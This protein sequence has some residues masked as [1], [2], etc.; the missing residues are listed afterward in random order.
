MHDC[1]R[2]APR[3]QRLAALPS[4]Q[5][6][7]GRGACPWERQGWV[8]HAKTQLDARLPWTTAHATSFGWLGTRVGSAYASPHTNPRPHR[9]RRRGRP[10]TPTA[11]SLMTTSCPSWSWSACAPGSPPA[12]IVSA[13]TR[14][15][16]A[17]LIANPLAG[18]AEDLGQRRT[19]LIRQ[20]RRSGDLIPIDQAQSSYVLLIG[21]GPLL[22]CSWRNARHLPPGRSHAGDRHLTQQDSGQARR[23]YERSQ[24]YRDGIS[25]REK[26][27][28][29][30]GR[31]R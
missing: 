6:R 19:Q 1:M 26:F 7:G 28:F 30:R 9:R 29:R 2:C 23:L 17:T 31:H 16:T 20:L 18:D 15:P 5:R 27:P 24:G 13:K 11:P 10:S 14:R 22:R 8:L 12:G 21:G 3:G 25:H 4:T